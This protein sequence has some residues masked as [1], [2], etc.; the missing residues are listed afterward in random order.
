MA[1]IEQTISE[2]EAR[3]RGEIRFAAESSLEAAA[4]F[5]GETARERALEVF[6]LLRVW[7][8]EENNGV[9]IYLLLAD[10]DVEIVA[11]RGFNAKV[12]K[13][14]WEEICR[15]MEAAFRRGDFAGGVLAGIA[16]VTALI[17][18]YYP[19][20]PGGRNELPDKPVIL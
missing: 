10:H 14:E 2:S 7:D 11:D 8:T 12:A 1:S 9:L 18:R 16:D 20:H 15:R 3:H 5:G 19:A 17:A 13:R 4:I 6:S